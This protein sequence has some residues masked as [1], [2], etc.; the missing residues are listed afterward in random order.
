MSFPHFSTKK[1]CG[2]IV[3]KLYTIVSTVEKG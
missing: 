2:K 1:Y 3:V